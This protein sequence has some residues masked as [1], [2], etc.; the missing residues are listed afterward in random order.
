MDNFGY[1]SG[2]VGRYPVLYAADCAGKDRAVLAGD[3]Y[4]RIKRKTQGDG[5]VDN[6]GYLQSQWMFL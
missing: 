2:G 5:F 6:F 1:F 4:R 3:G